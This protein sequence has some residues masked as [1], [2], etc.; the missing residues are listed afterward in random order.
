[1]RLVV[2]N[3]PPV[4]LA[5]PLSWPALVVVPAVLVSRPDTVPAALLLN[6]AA[7]LTAPVIVR[8]F[9]SVP[10][11]TFAPPLSWPLFV[12]V[13]AEFVSRPDTVPLTLLLNVAALLTAPVIVRLLLTVPVPVIPTV[14]EIRLLLVTVPPLTDAPPLSWPALVVVPAVLVS[15][16]DTVPAALLLNVAALLTAPAIVRLFA[17]VPRVTFAPPLSWPLFVVVPVEF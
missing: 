11:V 9:S 7:L 15:R 16:P 2:V 12:V 6:V 3:V 13:P 17:S 10:P 14:P 8:L 1:M 4:T 5:P